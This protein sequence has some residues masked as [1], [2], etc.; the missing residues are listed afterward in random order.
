MTLS[1]SQV[2]PNSMGE[3][4]GKPNYFIQ[5]IWES[6]KDQMVDSYIYRHKK[7]FGLYWDE[8]PSTV[9][10]KIHTIRQDES[11]RWKA[12][13]DIHFVINNRTKEHFRFAPVLKCVSVQSIVISEMIMTPYPCIILNNEKVF[14]VKVDQKYLAADKIKELAINDGF[15][16]IES[17]FDYFNEDFTGK[18]IHWT[19]LK[20]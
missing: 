3:L 18:I 4:A 13:I 20:Y 6:L 19:D 16:S 17:F 7:T 9:S 12:G 2:W 15:P 14:T 11:N 1:F 5:K 8:N 10:P